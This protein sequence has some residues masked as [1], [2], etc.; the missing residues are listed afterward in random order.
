MNNKVYV[1]VED[2]G[3]ECE[4]GVNI[5]LFNDFQNALDYKD[6]CANDIKQE[7]SNYDIV[8]ETEKSFSAYEDGNYRY[9]HNDVYIEE[10]E[11][12]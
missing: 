10:K 6:K 1:V 3:Y 9:S 8:E 5:T 12:L 7:T 4:Y 2:W 11:V